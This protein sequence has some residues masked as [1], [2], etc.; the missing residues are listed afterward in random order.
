MKFSTCVQFSKFLD[1]FYSMFHLV[2]QQLCTVCV[3]LCWGACLLALIICIP[4][5]VGEMNSI[6]QRTW[7]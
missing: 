7:W 5:L 3:V 1:T 4:I 2:S 6:N